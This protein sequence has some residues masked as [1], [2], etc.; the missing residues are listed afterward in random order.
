MRTNNRSGNLSG[1][2]I[3][4]GARVW[5]DIKTNSRDNV[6]LAQAQAAL[7]AVQVEVSGALAAYDALFGKQLGHRMEFYMEPGKKHSAELLTLYNAW[8][9]ATDKL[10]AAKEVVYAVH[11]DMADQYA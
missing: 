6:G 8:V 11:P 5:R 1:G 9:A 10:D 2:N 3:A 7:A 4:L